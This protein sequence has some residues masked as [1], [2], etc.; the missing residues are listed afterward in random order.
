MKC[1][2]NMQVKKILPKKQQNIKNI[3][4]YITKI[5]NT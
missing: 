4:K 2:K 1:F 5:E 3:K